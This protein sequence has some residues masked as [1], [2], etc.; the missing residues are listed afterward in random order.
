[1]NKLKI[2]FFGGCFNP[3]TNVH[4]NLANSLIKDRILDKVF[5]VPVGDYYEKQDLASA[6]DRYNMLKLACKD[7]EN[8]EVEDIAIT[9]QDKLYAV[10]TFKLIYEKYNEIADIYL[11]MGSDNFEK[12]PNWKDYEELMQNYKFIVLERL[13][14]K[15]VTKLENVLFYE[16]TP[17]E[18]ISST[19][20]RNKIMNNEDISKYISPQV[21]QYIKEKNIYLNL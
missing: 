13:N 20:I 3:P 7:Y 8:I 4:I 11:I 12:M 17:T 16:T 2:G 19:C 6:R 15:K 18:D 14:H 21:M 9:H 10:D 1:M 5:F